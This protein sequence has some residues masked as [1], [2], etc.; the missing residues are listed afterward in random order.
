MVGDDIAQNERC[1]DIPAE[2]AK[3]LTSAANAK[4]RKIYQSARSAALHR[5][6]DVIPAVYKCLVAFQRRRG[7][8]RTEHCALSEKGALHSG[9]VGHVALNQAGVLQVELGRCPDKCCNLVASRESLRDQC[10]PLCTRCTEYD[11]SHKV[12]LCSILTAV[13]GNSPPKMLASNLSIY[14]L[15]SD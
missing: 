6:D 13:A 14:T 1:H 7:T 3:L 2:E 15:Q 4:K 11:G 5:A 12:S 8:E 9:G 10:A